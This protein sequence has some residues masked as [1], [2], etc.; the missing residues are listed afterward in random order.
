M[1][2]TEDGQAISTARVRCERTIPI[3]GSGDIF[4]RSSVI[5]TKQIKVDLTVNMYRRRLW[6]AISGVSTSL[7]DL[8]DGTDDETKGPLTKSDTLVLYNKFKQ[9]V[10]LNKTA[11]RVANWEWKKRSTS[12]CPRSICQIEHPVTQLEMAFT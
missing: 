4:Q 7:T 11:H 5:V 1:H 8:Q 3:R 2:V 12:C 10:E 6:R 9:L